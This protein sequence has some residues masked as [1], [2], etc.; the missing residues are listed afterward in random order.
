[1]FC[2]RGIVMAFVPKPT[3]KKTESVYKTIYL[4]KT[5]ADTLDAIARENN[6]SFNN[7]VVSMIEH[8]LNEDMEESEK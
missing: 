6:T 5:L 4:S 1:M 3:K 7:V 8:C 2:K